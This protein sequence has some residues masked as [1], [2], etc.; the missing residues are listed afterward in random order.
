MQP[1]EVRNL[2]CQL[3]AIEA[4]QAP[5]LDEPVV[6]PGSIIERLDRTIERLDTTLAQLRG[7]LER[8]GNGG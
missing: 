4:R 3:E 6:R 8:G 5:R 1:E 7:L 2:I